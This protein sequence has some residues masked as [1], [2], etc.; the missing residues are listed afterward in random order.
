MTKRLI[1]SRLPLAEISTESAR[2][3]TRSRPTR[4]RL[5]WLWRAP[6]RTPA[7][8]VTLQ[9]NLSASNPAGLDQSLLDLNGREVLMQHG[10]NPDWQE[11]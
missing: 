8:S 11:S 3:S 4:Y 9:V 6:S 7:G 5:W 2:D 10:L 1:E